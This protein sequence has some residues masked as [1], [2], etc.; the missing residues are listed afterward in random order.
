M[1]KRAK[2][3]SV[4]DTKKYDYGVIKLRDKSGKVRHSASNGDAVA[5]AMAVHTA[6]GGS[7]KDVASAN[8]IAYKPNGRNPGLIRM[9][10]GVSLRAIVKSGKSVKIGK[11]TVTSLKQKV[12]VPPVKLKTA[13]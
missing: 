2:S 6:N 4:V 3:A 10:L 11:I 12:E 8:D 9:S 5:R 13:A 7:L 1:S